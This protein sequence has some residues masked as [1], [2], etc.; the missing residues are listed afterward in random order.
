MA[1]ANYRD[2]SSCSNNNNSINWAFSTIRTTHR[3]FCDYLL[4][5]FQFPLENWRGHTTSRKIKM[6]HVSTNKLYKQLKRRRNLLLHYF[7]F[8]AEWIVC[9]W[10]SYSILNPHIHRK[11][12]FP[13]DSSTATALSSH[14]HHCAVIDE[15]KHPLLFFHYKLPVIMSLDEPN[16]RSVVWKLCFDDGHVPS[17]GYNDWSGSHQLV[18]YGIKWI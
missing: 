11:K 8:R 5:L 7:P 18:S 12:S 17:K 14:S 10:T 13:S 3:S 6:S 4:F 2:T 9:V 1:G 16:Q 15:S